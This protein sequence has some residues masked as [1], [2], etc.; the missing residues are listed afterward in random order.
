GAISEFNQAIGLNSKNA[1]YHYHKGKA[2]YALKDFYGAIKELDI[3]IEKDPDNELFKTSKSE[4]IS[5]IDKAQTTS[6]S[7]YFDKV[8][9]ESSLSENNA[10]S[11]SAKIAAEH[12]GLE[13]DKRLVEFSNSS[14][15]GGSE[16]E[17]VALGSSAHN[18]VDLTMIG[19]N[20]SA[21]LDT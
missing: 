12:R 4:A 8:T 9:Q 21:G 17:N 16:E 5:F 6:S 13:A 10:S 11:S 2:L 3:A 18:T 20:E 14:S 19:E 7:A 1:S 15:S